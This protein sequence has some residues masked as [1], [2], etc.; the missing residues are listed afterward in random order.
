VGSGYFECPGCKTFFSVQS[1]QKE[2]APWAV[3]LGDKM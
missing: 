2:H 3:T 1:G